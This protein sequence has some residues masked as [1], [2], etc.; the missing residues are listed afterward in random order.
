MVSRCQISGRTETRPASDSSLPANRSTQS[1]ARRPHRSTTR[2]GSGRPL[3][4][5][6]MV[7]AG[8]PIAIAHSAAAKVSH[9]SWAGA[10]V[11]PWLQPARVKPPR[12]TPNFL[13]RAAAARRRKKSLL[14]RPR[15]SSCQERDHSSPDERDRISSTSSSSSGSSTGEEMRYTSACPFPQVDGVAMIAAEGKIRI[16]GGDDL[17]TRRAAQGCEFVRHH[18]GA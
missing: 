2:P 3:S 14:P 15:R 6:T 1:T 9:A 12:Q 8:I 13:V 11:N 16:L 17:P 4:R 7:A 10:S 5:S 18:N